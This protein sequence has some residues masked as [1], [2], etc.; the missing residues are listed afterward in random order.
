MNILENEMISLGII[1]SEVEYLHVDDWFNNVIII[2]S[3]SNNIGK[4][5]C[6]FEHCFSILLEH[7]KSYT[8]GCK[9]NGELDYK[10]FIQDIEIIE[11]K[12]LYNFKISAWPLY[13]E[14]LCKQIN[15]SID[16]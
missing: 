2:F 10:Y 16:D 1:D 5:I 11:D 12:N 15:I 8:K 13:G 6:K 9:N 3:G 4:V 7:D 14:I